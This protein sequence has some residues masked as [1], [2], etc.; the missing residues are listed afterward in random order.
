MAQIG[1]NPIASV[2]VLASVPCD[3]IQR[4]HQCEK[5]QQWIMS[6]EE[7]ARWQEALSAPDTRTCAEWIEA[8]RMLRAEQ[9]IAHELHEVF[10]AEGLR[11][12]PRTPDGRGS[13]SRSPPRLRA[14][15]DL[16]EREEV[17]IKGVYRRSAGTAVVFQ[18]GVGSGEGGGRS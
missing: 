12:P 8:D 9:E 3:H 7:R 11:T 18:G 1:S 2:N 17:V 10:F 5:D 13:R 14:M 4:H 15:E 16:H 6:T